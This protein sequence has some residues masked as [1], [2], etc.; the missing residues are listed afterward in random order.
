MWGKVYIL[1]RAT[2]ENPLNY[3]LMNNPII[4][5]LYHIMRHR[6]D[7]N[8]I[9]LMKLTFKQINLNLSHLQY[10]VCLFGQTNAL[11]LGNEVNSFTFLYSPT[12]VL[13]SAILFSFD[14]LLQSHVWRPPSSVTPDNLFIY[15]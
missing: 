12:R 14:T 15:K 11:I 13:T 8:L 4:N 5:L 7:L 2:D 6:F 9:G 3:I 10:I 1:K